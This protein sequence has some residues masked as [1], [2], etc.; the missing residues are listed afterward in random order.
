VS[1]FRLCTPLLLLPL[2][3]CGK[4]SG[5]PPLDS[6]SSVPV[7]PFDSLLAHDRI[8]KLLPDSADPVGFAA[9]MVVTP[10]QLFVADA[11]QA[12]LKVFD[13]TSGALLKTL[14]R[15]GDGPGEFRQPV[16]LA[17]LADGHLVAYDMTRGVLSI[18]DSLGA[19]ERERLVSGTFTTLVPIPGTERIVS[20]GWSSAAGE[21]A[22]DKD[23][24]RPLAHEI[25]LA[26][27]QVAA[28]HLPFKGS[29]HKWASTFNTP[30]ATLVGNVVVAGAMA[31]N[32]IYFHDRTTGREWSAQIGAPWYH[33]PNW[34]TEGLSGKGV[35]DRM[36]KWQREQEMLVG[37]FPLSEG[38]FLAQFQGNDAD[39]SRQYSYVVA[40]TAGH[41]LLAS[42]RTPVQILEI[43]DGVA[44]GIEA[45]NDRG[46]T[47]M[48]RYTL[49][50]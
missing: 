40:D 4:T 2:L 1:R 36:N 48:H 38:R 27:G 7:Q 35:I 41:S 45:D 49:R 26:D 47:I 28:S 8:V 17:R 22:F 39:G 24:R 5:E 10:T 18:W 3:A 12:N 43:R 37:L 33:R 20:G 16:A 32:A 30:S 15:A 34:P 44:W 21:K 19:F 29:E 25:S 31:S 46:E 9:A 13:P 6:F 23:G 14:G 11:M 50:H 42:S